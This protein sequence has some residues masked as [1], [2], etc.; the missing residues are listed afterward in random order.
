MT[1]LVERLRASASESEMG[2]NLAGTPQTCRQAADTIEALCEALGQ[3]AHD[4]ADYRCN[5]DHFGGGDIRTGRA[6]DKMRN[7]GAKALRVLVK[8]QS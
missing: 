2:R 6:W 3:L 7:S 1:S 8:A 4:E 5:H